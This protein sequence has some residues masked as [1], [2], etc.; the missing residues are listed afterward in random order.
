MSSD[1]KTPQKSNASELNNS[2]F[3]RGNFQVKRDI[4]E[5]DKED[6]KSA[7]QKLQEEF[8]KKALSSL[9]GSMVY[10]DRT[11]LTWDGD[12]SDKN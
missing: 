8:R 9:G 5:R 11:Q 4:V 7:A 12:E 1:A 2:G 3:L 10:V 6:S